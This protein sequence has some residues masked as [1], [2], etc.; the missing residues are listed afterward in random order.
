[1][2]KYKQ[3][4][5]YYSYWV[6]NLTSTLFFS[7][8]KNEW[9]E[10]PL[11]TPDQVKTS[12]LIKYTFTGD[13]NAQIKSYPA[14]NGKEEHFLKA[15]LVRVTHNCEIAPKGLYGPTEENPDEI[16]FTE[17]FKMPEFA[18]LSNLENWVHLNPHI[19]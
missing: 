3:G 12:R 14:F 5:N 16:E 7:L 8:V 11:V 13:L 19:L 18:E 4:A 6:N 1:M 9:H 15:Q 2:E 10:L 17:D